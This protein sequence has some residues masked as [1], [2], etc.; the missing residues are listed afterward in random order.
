MIFRV[1]LALLSWLGP[2]L[3]A[4][5][6]DADLP[7]LGADRTAI[8]QIYYTHRLGTKPPFEETLPPAQIEK[9]VALE[10]KKEAVLKRVHGV[11]ITAAMVDAEVRRI[12]AT[13][14]APEVLAELKAALGNDPAR[15]ARSMARPIVVERI[16]RARFENDDQLHAP[17]RAKVDALRP[18]L[19]AE[20]SGTFQKRAAL[21]KS[22]KLSE[23][24]EVTW[25]LA[26]RPSDDRPA[27]APSV[28]APATENKASSGAYSI[29]AT[30][31]VAQVLLS[32]EKSAV[33]R[34]RPL[35]FVDLPPDLQNVLQAQLKMPGDV[36]A[37]IETTQGFLLYLARERTSGTLSVAVLSVPKRGYEQWLAKQPDFG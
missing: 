18:Q 30:A 1:W 36:S 24:P 17:E 13:T 7:S 3:T 4:A 8:E 27:P 20:K 14:R 15:F 26:P 5:A 22:V 16:L 33:E 21:M 29:E 35:Y 32:P 25:Q 9:L 10:L 12:D 37:V 23:T 31:Q 6:K 19:L 2:M 11:E 34:E 28:P